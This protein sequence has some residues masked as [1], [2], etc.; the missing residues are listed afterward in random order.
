MSV[1]FMLIHLKYRIDHPSNFM[2]RMFNDRNTETTFSINETSNEVTE[3]LS[4]AV[5]L[6][7]EYSFRYF[8]FLICIHVDWILQSLSC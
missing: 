6:L 2:K 5:E 4:F 3:I 7:L 8:C 1:I